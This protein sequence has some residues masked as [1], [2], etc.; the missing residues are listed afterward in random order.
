MAKI[1]GLLRSFDKNSRAALFPILIHL[2]IT[3]PLAAAL[4]IW[5]DEAH[6]MN[7]ISGSLSHTLDRA[8]SFEMQPP[9]YFI[10]MNLWARLGSSVLFLRLFSVLCMISA[11]WLASRIS[12]SMFPELHPGWLPL[13]VAINPYAIWAA[14][15]MRL[16]AF[17]VLL[18]S[19][20]LLTFYQGFLSDDPAAKGKRK[21]F[22]VFC[23]LSLYTQYYA[24][25]LLTAM[26]LGLVLLKRWGPLKK[27]AGYYVLVV[28]SVLP[29]LL[30][31]VRQTAQHRKFMIADNGVLNY[32]S[33]GTRFLRYL[34]RLEWMPSPI[35]MFIY[36]ACLA[37]FLGFIMKHRKNLRDVHKMIGVMILIVTVFYLASMPFVN[38]ELVNTRHTTVLFIPALLLLVAALSLLPADRRRKS[39]IGALL[40][41]ALANAI[42]M[43]GE[44]SPMAKFGDSRRVAE[45]IANNEVS[46]Q[47]I[48]VF[49]SELALPFA[50]YYSGKN[51]V[52]PIPDKAPTT[53]YDVN[54]F[55][56]KSEQDITR[57]VDREGLRPEYVWVVTWGLCE[58]LGVD[59]HCEI[60]EK[61]IQN[62]FTVEDD[63][64]FYH[65]R[66]RLLRLK[67]ISGP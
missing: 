27:L 6:T 36:T 46:G 60:L 5:I 4:N 20:L 57:A 3:I 65:S 1:R 30:A 33:V 44:Y 13:A 55:A 24:A 51:I 16:Y 58:Y 43:V 45:Y 63:K 18:T 22:F 50:Y 2:S 35:Y 26:F 61:Y 12:K 15:E 8:M 66:V 53:Y 64:S 10:F 62:S 9:L 49:I 41:M 40:V 23:V 42:Y 17:L 11:I 37:G 47:P 59:Y 48:L 52:I 34:L 38:N 39:A 67:N 32:L 56:L 21:W 28:A 25:F 7:T 54:D 29:I 31:A 14:T 19:A